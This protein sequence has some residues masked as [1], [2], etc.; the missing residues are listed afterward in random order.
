MNKQDEHIINELQRELAKE[1]ENSDRAKAKG[2]L[3]GWAILVIPTLIW[4]SL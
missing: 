3:I 2:V 4:L 1:R